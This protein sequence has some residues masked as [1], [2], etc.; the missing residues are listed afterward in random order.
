MVHGR[1]ERV[2]HANQ[3]TAHSGTR[4]APHVKAALGSLN[5]EAHLEGLTQNKWPRLINVKE[6]HYA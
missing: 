2:L 1:P 3:A 6:G 5:Q 4:P